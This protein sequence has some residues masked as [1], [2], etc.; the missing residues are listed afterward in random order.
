MDRSGAPD[1]PADPPVREPGRPR[2]TGAA[3]QATVHTM[4]ADGSVTLLSDGGVLFDAGA[5]AV[6]EGGWRALRPGQ[7]VTVLRRGRVVVAVVHP[8]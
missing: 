4:H 5:A 1:D 8:V 3:E 2:R 7:R 6:A